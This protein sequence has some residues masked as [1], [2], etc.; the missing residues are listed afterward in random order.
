M[1][2]QYR[3][4]WFAQCGGKKRKVCGRVKVATKRK[5]FVLLLTVLLQ[6]LVGVEWNGMEVRPTNNGEMFTMFD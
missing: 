6:M 4:C 3:Q 2:S 1:L 5:M